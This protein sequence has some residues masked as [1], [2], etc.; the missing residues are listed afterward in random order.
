MSDQTIKRPKALDCLG[1]ERKLSMDGIDNHLPHD[2]R[3][4]L[5]QQHALALTLLRGGTLDLEPGDLVQ[6][7]LIVSVLAGKPGDIGNLSRWLLAARD[8]AAA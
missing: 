3:T 6:H 7:I 5:D 8:E 1:L 2:T 4:P